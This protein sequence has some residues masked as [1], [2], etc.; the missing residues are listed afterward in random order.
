MN[1][2]PKIS[3]SVICYN[4][5]KYIGSCLD[6]ILAQCTHL[7]F[8]IVVGDDA[9]QDKTQT[10]LLDYQRRYPD[11]IRLILHEKNIGGSGNY[12]D[13]AAECRGEYIAHVDGDDLM[14]QGKLAKQ[15]AFL[16][17]H[18]ECSM[19]VHKVNV[20]QGG[21]AKRLGK[22]PDKP[23]PGVSDINYLV[24]NHPF[25][26]ASSKMYRRSANRFP[27]RS[28]PTVDTLLHFEHA[29]VGDVGYLDE[30]LGEYRKV[31]N[32]MTD[33][34]SPGF[35]TSVQGNLDGFHRALEL[36]VP[37]EVVDEGLSKFKGGISLVYLEIGNDQLFKKYLEESR[38]RGLRLNFLHRLLHLLKNLPRIARS[39][40]R[41]YKIA[42]SCRSRFSV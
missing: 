20:I 13:V 37:K 24:R 9:S 35:S 30:T 31:G 15:A 16:D 25:F 3:V 2:D 29:S 41:F 23:K 21:A 11:V 19:V 22:I 36:G 6:S 26:V 38:E 34:Q 14:L 7:S 8:E 5:E 33:I 17:A 28:V 1:T 18:P 10:I 4:Q 12:Y 42:R 39:L 32:S 27:R 40:Y